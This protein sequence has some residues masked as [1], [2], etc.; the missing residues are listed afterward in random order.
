MSSVIDEFALI[1]SRIQ[2]LHRS[3]AVTGSHHQ[4]L[5]YA[6]AG[7]PSAEQPPMTG[8]QCAI[9]SLCPAQWNVRPPSTARVAPVTKDA[10]E[11]LR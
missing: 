11:L 3:R 2:Y 10:S 4:S 9:I 1:N 5:Q 7:K 8:L 6:T